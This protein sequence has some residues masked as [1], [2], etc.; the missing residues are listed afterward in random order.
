MKKIL[1]TLFLVMTIGLIYGQTTYYWVGGT[2]ATTGINTGANWNT[3]LDGSG[4]SRPSSTGT[5]DILVF[6]GT[7]LGGSTPATGPATILASSGI[8]F[9][10]MIFTNSV[11]VNMVRPTSGTSTLTVNGEAGEDFVVNAGSTFRVLNSTGSI[12]FAMLAAV[13]ACRV[14]GAVSI[15]TGLAI[16]I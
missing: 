9:A 8:S 16:P 5:T 1:F 6:D 15:I 4:S 13:D 10:Q 11:N 7:N 3:A 12:R 2:A 14:S